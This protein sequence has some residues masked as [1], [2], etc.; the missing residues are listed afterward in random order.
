MILDINDMG[1]ERMAYPHLTGV[2][3]VLPFTEATADA[4]TF[5]C[6]F[7]GGSSANETGVGLG[8]TG[9]DLVLSQA[10]GVGAASSGHRGLAPNKY[11]TGTAAFVAAWANQPEW[12]FFLEFQSNVIA[13]NATLWDLETST[14]GLNPQAAFASG[15]YNLYANPQIITPGDTLPNTTSSIYAGAWLKNN[16]L[17]FGW[18][19]TDI[20]PIGWDDFPA[21]Q[22]VACRGVAQFSGTWTTLRVAGSTSYGATMNIG[23]VIASK[24]GLAAAPI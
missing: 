20:M 22:R 15:I 21:T 11:F 24:I 10:G 9:A 14:R 7:T 2:P 6:E 12:S 16:I 17:H 5:V 3:V 19:I 23:R 8:L 1:L 4:N 13:V 18:K